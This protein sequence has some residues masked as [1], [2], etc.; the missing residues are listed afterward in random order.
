MSENLTPEQEVWRAERAKQLLNEPLI[1]EALDAIES[2]LIEQW[3]ATPIKDQEMRE[4]IWMMFNIKR[5]FV[6]RMTEHIETGKIASLQMRQP[7]KF[8]VF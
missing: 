7:R 4:K 2:L 5:N 3:S 1:K 6:Q 8:G